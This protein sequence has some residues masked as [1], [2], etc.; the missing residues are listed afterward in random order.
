PVF[1]DVI[2]DLGPGFIVLTYFVLVGTSN[3]VNLT[4]GLDGLAIMPTVLVAGA[5]G[6]FAYVSGNAV[7]ADYLHIPFVPGSGELVVFCGAMVGAGLGFLWFNTYPAQVFMGDVGALAL[8]A[9]LGVVAVIVRQEIVL[10]IMGG[11]FVM[12]T[13]SVILQVAS[14]KLTGRRIFRM[15]PLHHHFELKGWPEPRVIVRFW[16]IT[17]I[18]V[19]IGLATLKVR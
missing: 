4:D 18:L 17:V 9:A 14:Y 5:L 2:F 7:F 15:A 10:F 11:V 3:A 13:I 8:G 1:K 16:I 12:E 19:L 6:I